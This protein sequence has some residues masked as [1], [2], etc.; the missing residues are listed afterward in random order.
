MTTANRFGKRWTINECLQLQREYELLGWSIDRIAEKHQRTPNAIMFKLDE[1]K[2]AD[3]NTLY[4]NY[5][6]CHNK[7]P[8]KSRRETNDSEEEQE[9]E[10]ADSDGDG[11]GEDDET[12]VDNEEA[13]NEEGN[14]DE[15][16]VN[17]E[18][19]DADLKERVNNLEKKIDELMQLISTQN[20]KSQKS[21]AWFL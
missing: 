16:Y 20:N 4:N 12:Y 11:D 6:N 15:S 14:D 21:R 7:D 19:E 10:S 1:E 3:Y 9:Q 18:E 8:S 17:T 2:L 13:S 5:Y